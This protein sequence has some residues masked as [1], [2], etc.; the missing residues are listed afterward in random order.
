M[1]A[2]VLSGS[3]MVSRF[4]KSVTDFQCSSVSFSSLYHRQSLFSWEVSPCRPGQ[5]S[6]LT[7]L[8][9]PGLS[10]SV[11]LLAFALPDLT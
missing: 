1:T 11:F 3:S 2:L 6:L 9:L 5:H 8:C 4:L 7:S 10:A